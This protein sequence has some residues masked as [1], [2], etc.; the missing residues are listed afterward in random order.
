MARSSDPIR[1]LRRQRNDRAVSPSL[2]KS[3]PASSWLL[4]PGIQE[5]IHHRHVH[6]GAFH[7]G[8]MRSIRQ[9]RQSRLGPRPHIAMSPATFE[10][11]HFAD[12]FEPHSIGIAVDEEHRGLTSSDKTSTGFYHTYFPTTGS[13]GASP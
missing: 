9:D 5:V 6:S 11:E 1:N 13:R 10:P 8:H 2:V 12:M 4:R 3:Y 7:Q